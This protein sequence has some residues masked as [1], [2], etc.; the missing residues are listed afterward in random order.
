M[1][2]FD[3]S[4]PEQVSDKNR[5]RETYRIAIVTAG[6]MAVVAVAVLIVYGMPI[7]PW[8]AA[9]WA[10]LVSVTALFSARLI[11]QGRIDL[12]MGLI[13]GSIQVGILATSYDTSGL[14][15]SLAAIGLTSAFGLTTYIR[16]HKLVM[17][18]RIASIVTG[19]LLVALDIFEPFERVPNGNI[20]FT[21][22]VAGGVALVY[23]VL[24]LRRSWSSIFDFMR[25]SVRN[26]LTVIVV[27]A[28]VVPVLLISAFLGGMTFVQ[29]RDALL[30]NTFDR[31]DAIEEIKTNQLSG[32][33]AEREGDM[34]ALGDTMGSFLNEASR[35]MESINTL[36]RGEILR[37]FEDWDSD[38]RD[39]ATNSSVTSGMRDLSV[40]FQSLSAPQARALYLGNPDIRNAGDETDYSLAHAEQHSF[41][42]NYVDIHGYEDAFLI[43]LDG[44]VVYSAYKTDV[45]G[46]NLVSGPYQDSNLAKLYVDL[47]SSQDNK[48]HIA[49]V[50][51]FGETYAMFIG[52][53]VYDDSTQVG[54]LAYQLSLENI[55]SIMEERA[56]QGLTGES[57]LLAMEEDGS[58][59]YRSNRTSLGNEQ[60]VIGYDITD[61]ASPTMH[62]ALDG[63]S[64]GGLIA[65]STGE[66][67]INSY[68]PLDI[69][70]VNW[71]VFT[72]VNATEALSPTHLEG[73][74][75]FLST[76]QETYGYYDIFLIHP[77]GTIFYTVVEE[78]DYQ[79]NIL[80]GPFSSS[81]LATLVDEVLESKSYEF[82]DF[83]HYEPSAG[84]PAAFFGIPQ[85]NTDGEVE[86]IVAAQVSVDDINAIMN[87]AHGLGETGESYIIG[88]DILGRMDSRFVEN[89]GVESTIL[90]PDFAVDTEAVRSALAGE[91]GQ[92]TIIDFRGLPVLS[93]WKPFH[94]AEGETSQAEN[95]TWA[96]MT[97][98]DQSEALAPVNQLAGSL[99]LVI[100]LAALVLGALAVFMGTRFAVGF[101]KPILTLTE[102]ATQVAAGDLG[103]RSDIKSEDELGTLANTFNTMT[104]QLQE[105]LGG[106]EQRVAARTKDLETVAEVSTA[107]ATILDIDTLLQ[108]V[109]D[110]S[111]ERFELYHTHIYLLDESGQNL[112]LTS[113]AGEPGRIM[114]AEKRSIPLDSQQ[115]IV[116]HAAREGEG[117]IVNDVT[118]SPDFLPNP[119]LPDTHSEMAVPMIT[120]NKVIGVFDVQSELTDRFT[121]SDIQVKTTLAAQ[122]AN[123]IQNVRSFAQSKKQAELQSLVNVIGTRIQR[124]TSIEETLQ[125]AI[126]ELGTAIGAS[127]VKASVRPA[128][129]IVDTAPNAQSAEPVAIA[130]EG[131]EDD[132]TDTRLPVER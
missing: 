86:L 48:S 100:G 114:A 96:V 98:I 74:K 123:S 83:D 13:I 15:I 85:V 102:T 87:E 126:R 6:I 39:V 99:G 38:I 21:W 66:T 4:S 44:N 36:K 65:A 128:A 67:R 125:T 5:T 78:A 131:E 14:G 40:G 53:P 69:E 29:V 73:E 19:I 70:G 124:T 88:P 24:V 71:A 90:N 132:T 18:V 104:A 118:A 130:A 49:D 20:A 50:A 119:L 3:S 41:F 52:A 45:F 26:R 35:K 105:T 122:V 2:Q 37:L 101:V 9:I 81:N 94:I 79:T 27:G 34:V 32:Y 68:R 72:S 95:L 42:S 12:G 64:G 7:N 59:S 58:I 8:S 60:F 1:T 46:T 107:T 28:A 57:F 106:M 82:A 10:A 33:F 92:G 56:G 77:N 121:E 22:G 97:E 31:L 75:D 84:A 51:L 108:T 117:I 30:K 112:I 115:S 110:L 61:I 25:T 89:F 17:G 93:V 54:I 127:R 80:T 16:S 129:N 116:A 109:V 113:G 43:D 111:K 23:A 62:K 55:T 11:K 120:A 103:L 63:N 47:V 91:A 76:Y